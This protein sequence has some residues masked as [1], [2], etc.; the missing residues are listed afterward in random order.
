M[1]TYSLQWL[2]CDIYRESHITPTHLIRVTG[3][4]SVTCR[5]RRLTVVVVGVATVAFIMVCCSRVRKALVGK[6]PTHHT[7]LTKI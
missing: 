1:F 6:T 4:G 2:T 5:L 7:L 3:T